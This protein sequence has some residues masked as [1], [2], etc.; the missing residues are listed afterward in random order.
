MLLV[1]ICL[2]S[3][4]IALPGFIS[5]AG[6][7]FWKGLI[8]GYNIYLFFTLIE[9][10]PI[11]LLILALGLIFLPDR[12]FVITLLCVLLPF[13]VSDA[14]GKGKLTGFLT[15]I[16]PFIMYPLIGYFIGTYAYD[17]R[18]GKVKFVR[19]HKFLCILV[20]VFSL[21]M[22]VNF[23][24]LID[25]NK[26]IDK[27][28][29]QYVN[30]LYMSDTRVYNNY[31]DD[32]QKKMYMVLFEAI[33]S[34]ENTIIIEK[35]KYDDYDCD[36]TTCVGNLTYIA[37]EALLVDHPE[38]IPLSGYSSSGNNSRIK[39]NLEFSNNNPIFVKMGE[40]KIARVIDNIKKETDGMS[41]LEKIEYVYDWMGENN[42]Y[43]S[44]F[45]WT[46]KNQS[47]YNVFMHNNAVCAGFAKASQVIFQNI[48]IESYAIV[49]ESTGP[50]MWNVVKYE[51]QYYFF[52]S[53]VAVSIQ[54]KD[55]THY[56]KGLIQEEMNYYII[57]YDEWY[58]EISKTNGLYNLE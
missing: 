51:D 9:F 17:V 7:S 18:E 21:Y 38:L 47:I 54:N 49:G 28:S 36:D 24:K 58:P 45:T 37:F 12:A 14:Y 32:N 43:D 40:M 46:S 4:Y 30:D 23:T 27:S 52:D 3:L 19:E 56:Y 11:L 31:L 20:V 39:I 8:P 35:D 41:D 55:S 34:Y 2:I 33:K 57:A 53:T 26:L 29:K 48:G 16:L 15:L 42:T 44:T 50:H 25:G 22:Y 13:M 10:S 1:V 6:Y 5:K